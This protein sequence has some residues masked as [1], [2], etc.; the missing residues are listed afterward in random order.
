MRLK[1]PMGSSFYV[2][3]DKSKGQLG[4][5]INLLW[6]K[7]FMKLESHLSQ[8]ASLITYSD[9]SYSNTAVANGDFVK[10]YKVG[11]GCFLSFWIGN[12]K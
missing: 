4:S 6:V 9:N 1:M 5:L 7:V 10:R 11:S 3:I 2:E 8:N 12:Y